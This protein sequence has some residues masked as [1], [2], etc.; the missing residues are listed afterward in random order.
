L[1]VKEVRADGR[2]T[3]VELIDGTEPV[4]MACRFLQFLSDRNFSPNTWRACWHPRRAR[5]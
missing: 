2:L 4:E 3:T 1:K 5:A